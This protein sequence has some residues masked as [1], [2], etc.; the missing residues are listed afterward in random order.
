MQFSAFHR[1]ALLTAAQAFT[2]GLVVCAIVAALSVVI[3]LILLLLWAIA[4]IWLFLRLCCVKVYSLHGILHVNK[5]KLFPYCVRTPVL[6]ITGVQ[7]IQTPLAKLIGSC[8]CLVYT[9]GF[10]FILLG[11]RQSD[12]LQLSSLIYTEDC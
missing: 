8:W 10:T 1:G 3:A 4:C 7:I 9:S 6:H 2:A 5:G 11:I 12:A